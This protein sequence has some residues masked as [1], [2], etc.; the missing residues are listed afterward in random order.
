MRTST[1]T[2]SM[3][4]TTHVSLCCCDNRIL[5]P[6]A[7]DT[8]HADEHHDGEH[9]DGAEHEHDHHAGG[10]HHHHGL[11][12]SST[13]N[14]QCAIRPLVTRLGGLSST[15]RRPETAW[16]PSAIM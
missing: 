2:A 11:H 7:E 13:R 5:L 9:H 4:C 8:A 14:L 15:L 6:S 3:S 10:H 16:K 1:V 12:G